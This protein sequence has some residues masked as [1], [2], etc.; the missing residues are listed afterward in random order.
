MSDDQFSK[1][2]KE[3]VPDAPSPEHWARGALRRRRNRQLIAGGI[4][5]AVVALALPLALNIPRPGISADPATSPEPTPTATQIEPTAPGLIALDPAPDGRGG[6]AACYDA[7]GNPVGVIDG[8]RI[9]RGA[10][11][12]W[13]CIGESDISGPLEPLVGNVDAIVDFVDAQAVLEPDQECNTEFSG[14]YTIVLEYPDGT[15]VPV[16]GDMLSCG[17]IDD[18]STVRSGAAELYSLMR[19]LWHEQRLRY[20]PINAH[21]VVVPEDCLAGD[22]IPAILDDVAG[23]IACRLQGSDGPDEE[24]VAAQL[25][26]GPAAEIVADIKLNSTRAAIGEPTWVDELGVSLV[27]HWGARLRLGMVTHGHYQYR[28]IAGQYWDWRPSEKVQ[29]ILDEAE[30]KVGVTRDRLERD[31]F[32]EPFR[33]MDLDDVDRVAACRVEDGWDDLKLV[34]GGWL[35]DQDSARAASELKG[36]RVMVEHESRSDDS[37]VVLIDTHGN[38]I[39]TWPSEGGGYQYRDV[40]GRL[41]AWM[42]SLRTQQ[43]IAEALAD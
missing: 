9:A 39:S 2:F 1:A 35:S 12:A 42:P 5:M 30:E 41:W 21:K 29:H 22:F 36:T 26:P 34:A 33:E 3:I 43:A 17:P 6:A 28:D 11:R 13:L 38:S 32:T 4:G 14:E 10:E 19:R 16:H 18:G 7:D 23:A 37:Y 24:P 15:T 20:E 25:D 27:D 8:S 31:C 40:D